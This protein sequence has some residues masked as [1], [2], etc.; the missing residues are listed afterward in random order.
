[1]IGS[2]EV[3][4]LPPLFDGLVF[5]GEG[6]N[7]LVASSGL[8]A[9]HVT[10][11]DFL[12]DFPTV[13]E[14][15]LAWHAHLRRDADTLFAI[16]STDD[17]AQIGS[18]GRT[19]VILGLQNAEVLGGRIERLEYLWHVGIRVL[20][21]T[22]N[23]AN[24]V[25]DGCLESR[26]AGLT[27]FGRQVVFACNSIGM[28]V[29]VSHVGRQ[30]TLD[31]AA[32]SRQPIVAS[33]ANRSALAQSPRNKDDD[34]LRAIA[35]SG[36]M[37]GVSPYGP[38]CWQ[39]NGR[40][41]AETFL[42]QLESM[43]ELVGEDSVGI[44]TDYS[45]MSHTNAVDEVLSRSSERYPEIFGPYV[46]AFGGTLTA[47]YC[48]GLETLAAWPTIGRLVMG[49]AFR[50]DVAQKLLGANWMRIYREVWSDAG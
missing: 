25:A 38:I 40:P 49:A 6:F 47:R 19:G 22:Y 46:D 17:L 3:S 41:T 37:I 12:S 23:E 24:S 2:T 18:D 42:A 39:G 9:M 1:M 29:D 13:C 26:D 10:A 32:I 15:V 43:V 5:R 45:A 4:D 30:A 48:E 16:E 11:G 33:H 44:G 31:A 20:Q 14:Q 34:E 8:A 50:S 27:R 36:G 7:E 21:L 35:A 28:L